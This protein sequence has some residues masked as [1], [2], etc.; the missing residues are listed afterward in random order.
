MEHP[1][2][3]TITRAAFVPLGWF[4]P[5]QEDKVPRGARFVILIGNAGPQ[6]F[7]RFARERNPSKDLLDDWTRDVVSVLARDLDANAV[8]PFDKPPLPFL[9][10]ARRAGAGHVSPLGLN[11]HSTY[12]LWHAYRAAL[13]FS[14]AFDLPPA[15][16]GAHPCETCAEKPCL[17][18]CPVGAFTATGY[19]AGACA[20]HVE[21]VAGGDCLSGGCLARL[22]CP[23]GRAFTYS[24]RQAEFHMRAFLKARGLEA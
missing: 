12:G 11:I 19:D 3:S 21:S 17:S 7:R 13:L 9:T 16:A 18:A 20:V 22:A 2:L 6:M 23:V 15:S 24:T 8:F 5:R 10:W 14:V 1:V 4:E